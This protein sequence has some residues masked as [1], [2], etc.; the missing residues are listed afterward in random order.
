MQFKAMPAGPNLFSLRKRRTGSLR[1]ITFVFRPK[2]SEEQKTRHPACLPLLDT[3]LSQGC[4]SVKRWKQSY[5]NGSGSAKS[6]P[7]LLPHHSKKHTVNNLLD[8][9][10]FNF[11]DIILQC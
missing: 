1:V 4:E 9:N 5:F 3:P 2:L 10:L 8:I 7:L 6:M 11:L